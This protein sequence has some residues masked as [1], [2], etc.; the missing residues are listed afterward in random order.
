MKPSVLLGKTYATML[1]TEYDESF[2]IGMKKV[3][4]EQNRTNC[5]NTVSADQFQ[6][7]MINLLKAFKD[8]HHRVTVPL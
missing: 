2:I 1:S 4:I 3:K 5:K 8:A 6:F 7:K